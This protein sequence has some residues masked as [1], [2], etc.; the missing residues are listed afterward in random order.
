MI[1]YYCQDL[2]I[3]DSEKKEAVLDTYFCCL[4]HQSLYQ[5]R[6]YTGGKRD[7]HSNLTV[8]EMQARLKEMGRKA[9]T[10]TDA[11]AIFGGSDN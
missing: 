2:E 8:P 11:E 3:P 10:V 6:N 4:E 7:G 9:R 5:K 1:C